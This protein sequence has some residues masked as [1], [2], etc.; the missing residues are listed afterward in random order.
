MLEEYDYQN[1][2]KTA[3]K[4]IFNISYT[5]PNI[6][7]D[8]YHLN[9]AENEVFVNFLEIK[10][11]C[12]ICRISFSFKS[13]FYK[14][15]K[16][17]YIIITNFSSFFSLTTP[18]SLISIINSTTTFSTSSSGFVFCNWNYATMAITL[19]SIKILNKT[20]SIESYCLNTSHKITLVD[21]FWLI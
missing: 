17:K 16:S 19:I 10:F 13:T 14:Y 4:E 15:L 20:S 5:K 7:K 18:F 9:N 3:L 6:E 8:L 11:I 21:R 2:N 12:N 1:S